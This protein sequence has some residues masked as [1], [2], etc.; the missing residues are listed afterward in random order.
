ME[1]ILMDSSS[2]TI[3][4]SNNSRRSMHEA[5]SASLVYA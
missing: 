3:P 4:T 1:K 5:Q 2:S